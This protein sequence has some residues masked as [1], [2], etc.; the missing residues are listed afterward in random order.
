VWDPVEPG[1]HM[2]RIG[3]VLLLLVLMMM[4]CLLIGIAGSRYMLARC[5]LLLLIMLHG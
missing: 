1:L 2:R 5:V 3:R 4:L